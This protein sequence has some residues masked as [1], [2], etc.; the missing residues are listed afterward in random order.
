MI[1]TITGDI[2]A[3]KSTVAKILAKNLDYSYRY[4]GNYMRE[5]AERR[6]ISLEE[7]GEI[8]KTDSSIDRE[9]DDWQIKIGKEDCIVLD[10]RIGW[11]FVPNSR[12]VFLSCDER[13]AAERT[14]QDKSSTRNVET[15]VASIEAEMQKNRKRRACERERYMKHYGVDYLDMSNYDIIVDTSLLTPDEVAAS[16]IQRLNLN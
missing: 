10:A 16:I 15:R 3:G 8:A 1:I 6:S 12:K 2:G 14:F 9:I 13:V 5:M 4:T 11:Y 7:L